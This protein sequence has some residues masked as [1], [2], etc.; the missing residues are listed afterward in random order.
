MTMYLISLSDIKM[1]PAMLSS[2]HAQFN[3][4]KNTIVFF[5]NVVSM[6][7]VW[8]A[9]LINANCVVVKLH[10]KLY[11]PKIVLVYF[12]YLISKTLIC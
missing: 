3:N 7:S 1:C 12:S 10:I 2:L 8:V 9:V 6:F 11:S 4:R 5:L